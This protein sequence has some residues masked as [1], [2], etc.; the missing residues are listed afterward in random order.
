MASIEHIFCGVALA[1]ALIVTTE[2]ARAESATSV[3]GVGSVSLAYT[4]NMFGV[5]S[6]TAPGQPGPIGVWFLE[7]SPGLMLVHETRQSLHTLTYSHPFTR[8]LGNDQGTQQSDVGA[9][10]GLFTPSPQ[11]EIVLG[12]TVERSNTAL[13]GFQTTPDQTTT[14]SYLMGDNVLLQARFSQ[15]YAREL[16]PQWDM[17]V[18]SGAGAVV[19]VDVPSPQPIRYEVLVGGGAEHAVGTERYAVLAEG[20]YFLTS[21][22]DEPCLPLAAT[23]QVVV[24]GTLRWRHDLNDLWS[25]ELSGGVAGALRTDPVRGGVWGPVALAALRYAEE[26]HEGSLVVQR[27]L[28]PDLLTA[29]TLMADHLFM[30]GGVPLDRDSTFVV[31]TG[32]G[33]AHNR[34]LQVEESGFLAGSPFATSRTGQDP[35]LLATFDTLVFDASVGWYP[36][37]LPFVEL[38]GQHLEQVGGTSAEAGVTSFQRNMGMLTAGMT[39]PSREPA[40]MQTREPRPTNRTRQH[41]SRQRPVGPTTHLPARSPT[42]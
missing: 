36:E 22:V 34:S 19:P 8:Y 6:D 21:E 14:P 42:E 13:G 7:A 4:D 35:R 3:H 10:R 1:A 25:T 37:N 31:R 30:A 16:S 38:R 40:R 32:M 28:G 33:Y 9:W 41:E 29:R 18:S 12:L 17:T 23:S 5:P 20:T 2:L 27:T 26:G 24:S 39:W 11:D 15:E